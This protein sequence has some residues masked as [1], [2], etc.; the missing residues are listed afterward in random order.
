MKKFLIDWKLLKQLDFTMLITAIIICIFGSLN[1]YSVTHGKSGFHFLELQMIWVLVGLIAA[2]FVILFDYNYISMYANVIYWAS[3]VLVLY[4]D[5]ATKAIKGANSWIRIGSIAIEPGEFLK[6]GLILLIAKKLNEMEGNIN[7]VKNFLILSLYGAIPVILILVQPNL[8]MALICF[9]I[10]LGMFFISGL[11]LKVIIGGF[12]SAI[13]ACIFVWFSGLMKTYQKD[14]ILAF[15]NPSAYQQSSSFQLM[16]SMIGIGSGELLGAGFL[17]GIQASG[18][19]IP[20]AHT[21]FIFSAV[22]EE[23]GLV[24]ATVLLILYGIIIYR[25]IKL[26]K[27]SKDIMGRLICVGTAS[28]FLFSIFQNIGMTI[29]LMPVA[30]ITLPFMSYGGSSILAN[31]MSLALVLNVSMR[32]SKINF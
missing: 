9:F 13:P 3:V 26:A 4:T 24:G 1:I 17:K 32:K 14:R 25:M 19:F 29:G 6:I 15:L 18:G 27:E 20:E 30:G 7:N 11:N 23:W 10:T 31:F 2:Y 12:L 22:G 5:I 21:D 28:A 8:G 16:Q